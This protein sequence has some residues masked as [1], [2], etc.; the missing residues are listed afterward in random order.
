MIL[1]DDA[2]SNIDMPPQ[3]VNTKLMVYGVRFGVLE[4]SLPPFVHMAPE[5]NS[6]NGK[7]W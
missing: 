2:F 6:I 1:H 7:E 5:A 3:A 4:T